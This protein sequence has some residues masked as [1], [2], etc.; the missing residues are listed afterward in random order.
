MEFD[1]NDTI[2]SIKKGNLR[3]V[4]LV[5]PTAESMYGAAREAQFSALLEAYFDI[6][7]GREDRLTCRWLWSIWKS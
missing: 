6:S 7:W 4:D 3:P 5:L 2:A 1:A